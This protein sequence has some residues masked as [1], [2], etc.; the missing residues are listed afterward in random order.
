MRKSE[1][2]MTIKQQYMHE[3]R[4]LQNAARRIAKE[5]ITVQLPAV[6]KKITRA[7][8][9]RLMKITPQ[10]LRESGTYTMSG[11]AV[12]AL[13]LRREQNRRRWDAAKRGAETRRLKKQRSR[14]DVANYDD[15]KQLYLQ[16]VDTVIADATARPWTVTEDGIEWLIQFRA[17]VEYAPAE[18]VATAWYDSGTELYS[19]LWDAIYSGNADRG[20]ARSALYSSLGELG[21]ELGIGAMPNMTTA[22]EEYNPYEY[23]DDEGW[24]AI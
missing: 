23:D 11:T 8:V 5:G 12:N 2:N 17:A 14:G 21:N 10:Q 16:A 13:E 18:G 19:E 4:R 3:R 22:F 24:D 9:N 15:Q 6:P 1:C 7:S 20:T